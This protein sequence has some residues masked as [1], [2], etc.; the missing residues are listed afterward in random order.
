MQGAPRAGR[1]R[2]TGIEI[3]PEAVRQ[4]RLDAGLSLAD[5]A[6]GEVTRGTIHLVET[7]K[8]RPSR[9]TLQLIARK[10]GRPL[11][12]FLAGP[13]GGEEQAALRA[14]FGRLLLT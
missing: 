3:R 9:R 14:R 5:V 8:M 10:T 4:A 1:G 12:Y 7:G 6:E 11:T 2:L 13:E